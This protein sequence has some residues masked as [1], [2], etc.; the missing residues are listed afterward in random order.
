MAAS[1]QETPETRGEAQV[2]PLARAVALFRTG[3]AEDRERDLL[4]FALAVQAGDTLSPETVE[5]RRREA[6]AALAAWAHRYLHNR[7]E[8]IRLQAVREHLGRLR[9]APGFLRLTCAAFAGIVLG[10]LALAWASGHDALIRA[11]ADRVA[12][13]PAT[14]AALIGGG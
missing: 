10:A 4:A 12:G 6:D 11:A 5:A 3:A 9:P 7:V 2:P 13:L 1:V 8:E 14:L